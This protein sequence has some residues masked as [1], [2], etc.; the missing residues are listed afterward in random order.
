METVPKGYKT[1][2]VG[3]I[4]DDWKIARIDTILQRVRHKVDVVKTEKYQQIGIRSHT[5]GIFH[6]EQVT[7]EELRNKSVFW[8]KENCFIVNIVF[9]W[10]H[11]IAKTTKD[12]I[13]MIASH[14]FPMYEPKDNKVDIDYILYFFKSKRGKYL[15]GLASPGG[16]GRNKTLGQGEFSELKIPI[17][18]LKEQT[19]IV[20]IL[21][22]IDKSILKQQ[23]LIQAK[24]KQ[25]KGLMQKLLSGEV[26]FNEFNDKWV[27]VRLETLTKKMQSGGTPKAKNKDY[28]NGNIPFIKIKDITK[29]GKHLLSTKVSI[30]REGL[31]SSSAWLVPINSLIY[32][33]YASIGFVCINK[34]EAA[35]S[36]AMINIIPDL[37][38]VDLE[39][40]YY[41]LYDLKK[42]I[43]KFIETGT[44]GNLNAQI[45]KNFKINIPSILEQQKIAKIFSI[46]DKEIDLLN[47][48]L[49]DLKDQKTLLIQKLLTGEVKVKV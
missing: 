40:L 14:R 23:E 48:E 34:I 20:D 8:I 6:K 19:K 15:L 45:V 1:T 47:N 27:N 26:R 25:F 10:E 31:E 28:Y 7:G 12:E 21:T 4:P 3:I 16:A 30:T 35:T 32:S 41:Y 18:S 44:Q 33:M 13:G 11:A 22:T 49:K 38:K 9:A 5:K 29:S 36:Q 39:Y 2:K 37:E 42:Y 46:A 17:P 43:S 24:E